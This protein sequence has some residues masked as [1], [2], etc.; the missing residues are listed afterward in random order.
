MRPYLAETEGFG[1]LASLTLGSSTPAWPAGHAF[2]IPIAAR[3]G[4]PLPLRQR[5]RPL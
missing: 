4:G 2:R 5:K 3:A 1:H